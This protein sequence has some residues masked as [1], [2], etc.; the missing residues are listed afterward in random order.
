[1][2]EN[3]SPPSLPPA[4]NF[5]KRRALPSPQNSPP[6][7]DF[8]K[9]ARQVIRL[10]T[11]GR[12]LVALALMALALILL[13]VLLGLSGS[14]RALSW[15]AFA[16]VGIAL[17][18]NFG[19][20]RTRRCTSENA[21]RQ[22]EEA[23]P[24]VGQM[25]RTANDVAALP[26][27]EEQGVSPDFARRLVQ[28]AHMKLGAIDLSE[29]LPRKVSKDWLILGGG[30]CFLFLLLLVAWQ[31]FRTGFARLLNPGGNI[32]FSQV[33]VVT[34]NDGFTSAKPPRIQA[35]VD[36]R[37]TKSATLV[38]HEPD[39]TFT[40][41]EMEAGS[42][43]DQFEAV[44]NGREATFQ[45]HILAGD[46]R[47]QV[48]VMENREPARLMSSSAVV[49]PPSYLG[50]AAEEKEQADITGVEGSQVELTF[51]MSAPLRKAHLSFEDGSTRSLTLNKK[52]ALADFELEV[53]KGIYRFEAVDLQGR[54]VEPVAFRI[55]GKPDKLPKIKIL[56]PSK[57]ASAT[58]IAEVPVRLRVT[59]DFGVA[60]LGLV[61]EAQGEAVTIFERKVEARDEIKI[62]ELAT[63]AL[64]QFP[65]NLRDNVRLYAYATDYKPRGE[66]RAVSALKSIDIKQ[67]K[68]RTIFVKNEGEAPPPP[69]PGA[70]EALAK[71]EELIKDQRAVLSDTFQAR[72]QNVQ[73]IAPESVVSGLKDRENTLSGQT[74]ELRTFLASKGIPEDDLAL[75]AIAAQQMN[76]AVSLLGASD[77]RGGF[78]REDAAL[79]SLLELRKRI[80][81]IIKK[82]KEGEP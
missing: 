9:K 51:E 65:L 35:R 69:P 58:A 48:A 37:E 18:V 25:L 14:V 49:T 63:A 66:Q 2:N 79:S 78:E 8:V 16:G 47:S 82:A 13:D 7:Q 17:V 39:G 1:M 19:W 60:T 64:E 10:E 62:T 55:N 11:M 21:T 33:A 80:L 30:L 73:A 40:Q 54:K 6:L 70:A 46:A 24:E 71:L 43:G 4:S 12:V 27:P 31:D 3:S 74:L 59:D 28:Q 42:D 56:D 26:N 76:E 81:Q 22:I 57:D 77:L 53:V 36:G 15:L 44:L 61:L 52:Q 20:R 75:L 45:Y 67:F 72:E 23:H 32:T 29:I 50:K 68:T 41:V 5:R 34:G 38:I